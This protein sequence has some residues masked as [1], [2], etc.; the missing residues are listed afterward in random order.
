MFTAVI[1]S[2]QLI[3]IAA[4]GA[5]ICA[6]LALGSTAPAL[7]ERAAL[8]GGVLLFAACGADLLLSVLDWRRAPLEMRRHL[9]HAFAIGVPVAMQVSLD[10]QGGSRRLGWYQEYADP[11]LAM[12]G[13]PMPFDVGPRQRELLSVEVTP[14]AR[15][16]QRFD[17]GQ[18]RLRSRLGLLDLDLR[19]GKSESRRVFPNFQ[20]QARFALLAGDRRIQSAGLKSVQRRGSGTDFD[21]LTDYR[22]GDPIRHIDWKATGKHDRPIVRKF[23][24]ERDQDVMILLDCGRRMRADDTQHGIGATHFDQCLNALML[25]AFVA[26][27]HGDA[28]GAMTFGVAD[29]MQKRFAP[30]KGR[31]TLNA[32][33]ADLADVEATAT[34]SDYERIAA[35]CLSQRRK[36]GLVVMIT[37]SRNEDAPELGAALALLRTRHIVILANLREEVVALIG[38]QDL[39]TSESA[40]EC[41]AALEYAHARDRLLKRLANSGVCTI[42]C[43][44]RRLGVELVNRYRALKRSGSI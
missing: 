34:F 2:R 12:P 1:P 42:D 3:A 21:Q 29:G 10:N 30:R 40:L 7:V 23:Q 15:G 35:D 38:G 36:R 39:K 31:H 20:E 33:M 22:A 44:P 43:E 8:A 18:V 27:S 24:D 26:L 16:L 6:A 19:I 4:V 14:T 28:V 41:A 32:L 9:P 37:N 25:L 11:T 13:L 17:A 5:A